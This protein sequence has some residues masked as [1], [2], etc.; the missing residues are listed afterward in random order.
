MKCRFCHN[1]TENLFISLGNSPLANSYLKEVD[2]KQT[3]PFYP[4]NVYVCDTCFY[5]QA[6]EVVTPDHIFSDYDYFSSYSPT[7]LEHSKL[8]AEKMIDKLDLNINSRV[9]ELASN[10]GYLLQYFIQRKI[11]VLGVEPAANVAA[12]AIEKGIDT[13]VIFFGEETAKIL[14]E[15]KMGA[16]LL[17]GNNVLAHVP[18]IN[19]FVAGMKVLLKEDGVITMEFPHL[20]KLVDQCLFDTIYHEHFSYFSFIV[21]NKIFNSHKLKIYDVDEF[22]L[23]GGSLRIYACHD[24]NYEKIVTE[25]VNALKKLELDE[26]YE[27]LETY[28]DFENKVKKIRKDLIDFLKDKK[29]KDKKI[30]G[31]GAPAKGNTLLNYCGIGTDLIDFTV[32]KNP[33]KQGKYLPGSH[34]PIKSFEEIIKE[35]PDYIFILPWNFKDEIMSEMEFVKEWGCQFFIAVPEIE[36]FK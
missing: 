13:E 4:L 15:K 23:H 14:L 31:Y 32:D 2:L 27:N 16:D 8:Y 6:Q 33:A 12:V 3:E 22:P 35:K 11:P 18:R 20:K 10:D 24:D 25:R 17:I 36:I 7:W 26:G 30:V 19:D 9:V 29:N 1:K 5:V 21:V 34:L 28:Q